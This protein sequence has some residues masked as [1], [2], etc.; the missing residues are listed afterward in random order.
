MSKWPPHLLR[1]LALEKINTLLGV[2]PDAIEARF[3]R[4][5]LLAELG[6]TEEAKTAYLDVLTREPTHFG[7]LNDF[8][9]LLYALGFKTAARTLYMEA[10]KQHPENPKGYVNLANALVDNNELEQAMRYFE[11]ALRLDPEHIEANR[12]LSYLLT[13]S[14]DE[15]RAALH[16]EK[17]FRRRPVQVLAYR[18]EGAPITILLLASASGG[19]IPIR[20]HLDERVFLVSVIFVEFYDLSISLPPHQ[21]VINAIG[22]ADLCRPALEAA[23]KIVKK[24]AAP[25]INHPATVLLTGRAQNAERF[26]NIKGLVAPR[27]SLLPRTLLEGA[28]AP[29]ILAKKGFTFPLLLR[30]PGFHAGRHF[31]RIENEQALAANL[32][33][34]PG[35]ELLVIQYLDARSRDGKIRK[36]RVMMIGGVL[37]PLHVAIS[38]DWKIHYF[39]AEMS[40]NPEHQAEDLKFL[41]NMVEVLGARVMEALDKI[42]EEIGLDYGGIDFSLDADGKIILFEANA[43]MVVNL[44]DKDERRDYRRPAV[45]R[46]LDA[47]RDLMTK[48]LPDTD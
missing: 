26:T 6:R 8:G 42:R 23:V 1:E 5:G 17:A 3:N 29:A 44:P 39:T 13:D 27:I 45:Q 19:L 28:D 30:S 37:Y 21:L 15:E 24:T 20:H 16:R 7:A 18:G 4:A 41:D 11:T 2:S 22:D 14:R 10:V 48:H 12:G 31:V 25:V 33:S 35:K 47:I 46:I 40:D 38:R 9:N 43:T 34:V 36:Y 32:S